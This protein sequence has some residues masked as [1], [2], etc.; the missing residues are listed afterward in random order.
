VAEYLNTEL[1][2]SFCRFLNILSHTVMRFVHYSDDNS[3]KYNSLQVRHIS[4]LHDEHHY[5]CGKR[6]ADI[7]N[8]TK[9]TISD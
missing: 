1:I 8:D 9:E 5:T 4:S 2:N 3:I 6:W 7:E